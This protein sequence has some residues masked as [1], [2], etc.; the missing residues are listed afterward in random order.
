ME[1]NLQNDKV[2]VKYSNKLLQSDTKMCA[3]F[4]AGVKAIGT[5]FCTA[6]QSVRFCKMK[7]E[8]YEKNIINILCSNIMPQKILDDILN[9]PE[10]IQYKYTGVGYYLDLCDNRLPKNRIIC[11]EQKIYGFF[12]KI[13][14]G[15][16]IFIENKVLCLE[17]F[18]YGYENILSKIRTKKPS[19]STVK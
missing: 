4:R 14:V 16:I 6:E 15:S 12:E 9:K 7:I 10:K 1:K 11:G 8:E 19:I 2:R 17:C 13:E 5:H 18:T 3:D